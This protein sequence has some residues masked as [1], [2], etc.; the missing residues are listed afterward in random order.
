VQLAADLACGQAQLHPSLAQVFQLV[1]VPTAKVREA[2]KARA[3][4]DT[5]KVSPVTTLV[6]AWAQASE[7]QREAAVRLIGPA[8]HWSY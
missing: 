7:T 1:G 2:L 5:E 6:E 4:R 3:A 8:T